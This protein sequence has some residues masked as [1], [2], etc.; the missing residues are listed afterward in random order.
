MPEFQ[1]FLSG[2]NLDDFWYYVKWL[3]FFSAPVVMIVF[4]LSAVSH[5]IDVIKKALK[6][7][8][9]DEKDDDYDVYRY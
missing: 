9:E 3:L 1:T 2:S 4:A 7:S 8:D 5:L 6:K